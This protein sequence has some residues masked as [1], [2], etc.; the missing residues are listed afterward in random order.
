MYHLAVDTDYRP[1]CQ[2][3]Q[4]TIVPLWLH[5]RYNILLNKDASWNK[6][7]VIGQLFGADN[8]PADN[9]PK[10]YRSTSSCSNWPHWLR[11]ASLSSRHI[12]CRHRYITT[13]KEY[14]TNGQILFTDFKLVF[15][16]LQLLKISC[17]FVVIWLSYERKKRDAFY[18]RPEWQNIVC[19]RWHFKNNRKRCI[20]SHFIQCF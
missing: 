9:R 6:Q 7:S 2:C 14:L 3:Y 13:S 16:R 20:F 19:C 10:H 11:R 8:R 17:K 15:F 5:N 1:V 18:P 4:S 12:S